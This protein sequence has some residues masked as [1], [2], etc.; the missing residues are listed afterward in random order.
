MC[1]TLFSIDNFISIFRRS[2]MKSIE[3]ISVI[4]Y[5]CLLLEIITYKTNVNARRRKSALRHWRIEMNCSNWWIIISRKRSMS[6]QTS[7]TFI[8]HSTI[9]F[10]E[11]N[12]L[13]LTTE[14]KWRWWKK[15]H[16][17]LQNSW[18]KRRIR[19]KQT[20]KPQQQSHGYI[21]EKKDY[22][23]ALGWWWK[24]NFTR[25]W[26]NSEKERKSIIENLRSFW[27]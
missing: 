15:Y 14:R 12:T 7:F 9:H 6:H 2:A 10:R 22:L 27:T 25:N 26:L 11:I 16:T 21:G 3:M 1:W 17:T 5:F 18:T 4:I 24:L 8:M 20:N 19:N 23:R 13:N